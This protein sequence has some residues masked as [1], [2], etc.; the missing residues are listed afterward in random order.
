MS[1][2]NDALKK[3]QRQRSQ[4]PQ[5]FTPSPSN[6][7]GRVAKRGAPMSAQ[8]MVLI[9]AGCA[10]LVVISAVSAVLFVNSGSSKPK[11]AVVAATTP[12]PAPVVTSVP[13]VELPSALP[14]PITLPPLKKPAEAEPVVIAAPPSAPVEN[15]P[16]PKPTAP[17]SRPAIV[18]T[19]EPVAVAPKEVAPPVSTSTPALAPVPV[20]AAVRSPA[21]PDER[22]N[23]YLD[24]LR[25]TG[26]RSSGHDSRVLMNEKVFRVNDMVDRSLGLKL[27]VVAADHLT[28]TDGNG[29]TYD[30]YF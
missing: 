22:V 2:I 30:K 19:P 12:T 26:V 17:V 13:K 29:L 18:S 14:A 9:G 4:A 3:A 15:K 16:A 11:P 28:F 6:E 25:I 10:L 1:L 21:V 27:T 5:D 23:A 20:P 8:T 24:A 7:G